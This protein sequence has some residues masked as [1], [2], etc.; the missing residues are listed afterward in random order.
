MSLKVKTISGKATRGTKTIPD[1]EANPDTEIISRAKFTRGSKAIPDAETTA[2]TETTLST[3]AVCHLCYLCQKSFKNASALSTHKADSHDGRRRRIHPLKCH[4]C[5]SKSVMTRRGLSKHLSS[6]QE[7]RRLQFPLSCP[8]CGCVCQK[9]EDLPKHSLKCESWEQDSSD[10]EQVLADFDKELAQAHVRIVKRRTPEVIEDTRLGVALVTH[11]YG[12]LVRLN[13]YKLLDNKDPIWHMPFPENGEHL[14]RMLEGLLIQSG[15]D[16]LLALKVEVYGTSDYEDPHAQEIAKPEGTKPFKVTNIYHDQTHKVMIG[17][18]K[19]C[20]L[21][22][23]AVMLTDGTVVV[24]PDN[25]VFN[26][27]ETSSVW[28]KKEQGPHLFNTMAR[29]LRSKFNDEATFAPYSAVHTPFNHHTTMP[30]TLRTLYG[31]KFNKAWSSVKVAA[32][33]FHQLYTKHK[34]VKAEIQLHV[35]EALS[36][37]QGKS[38]EILDIIQRMIGVMAEEESF[39]V[40]KAVNACLTE[41]AGKLSGEITS[42]NNTYVMDAVV[43]KVKN[44]I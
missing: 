12:R 5:N 28:I 25:R 18:V 36:G 11:A 26:P 38:T 16:V 19:W 4:W 7:V 9:L 42:L 6:C 31:F 3:T 41:L 10:D 15:D 34:V 14:A 29:Q 2:D 37:N 22:T 33:V 35:E 39:P 27:K 17:T 13:D 30:V 20:L 8:C 23:L 24:G 21:V 43:K 32:F 44:I 40:S 1:P